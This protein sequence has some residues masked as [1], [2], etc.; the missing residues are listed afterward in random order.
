MS[1]SAQ[2]LAVGRKGIAELIEA[3]RSVLA[4]TALGGL[5]ANSLQPKL[6]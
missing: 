1:S 3:Q 6:A 2:M 5:S 4:Q